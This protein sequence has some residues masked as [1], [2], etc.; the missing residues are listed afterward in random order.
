MFLRVCCFLGCCDIV[1]GPALPRVEQHCREF[2]LAHP[3]TAV[4]GDGS[5]PSLCWRYNP[6]TTGPAPPVLTQLCF[7]ASSVVHTLARVFLGHKKAVENSHA[8][9]LG[10]IC[11]LGM[12]KRVYLVAVTFLALG[13]GAPD[14]SSSIAA[15][16]S[17]NY[18]LALG[19]LLGE[20]LHFQVVSS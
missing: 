19:A 1:A 20:R 13:N 14:I 2:L 3:D 4:T 15:I 18:E 7:I 17:G 10:S 9:S 5:A 8:L 11:S 6:L 12:L 16:S